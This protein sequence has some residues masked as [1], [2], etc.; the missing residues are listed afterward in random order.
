MKQARLTPESKRAYIGCME[1][2][3]K[4]LRPGDTLELPP[5]EL[6]HVIV[7]GPAWQPSEVWVSDSAGH[8]HTLDPDQA[9]LVE[10]AAS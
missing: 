3:A 1:I 10:R 4:E 6:A 5:L 2:T 8:V 9:L 7:I